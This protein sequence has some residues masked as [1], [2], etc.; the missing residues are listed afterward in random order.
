MSIL[1]KII[2]AG[3]I[4]AG[5][6]AISTA[7]LAHDA[8]VTPNGLGDTTSASPDKAHSCFYLSQWQNWHAPNPDVIYLRVRV[9]DIYRLDLSHPEPMLQDAFAH[10]ISREHG[11]DSVCGP[12]DLD[13]SVSDGEGF[14]APIFAKSITRL[15]PQQIALIPRKDLP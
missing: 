8:T 4:A 9:N 3:S 12:I 1:R 2:A 5:A 10:L 11:D 7:G 14:R 6:L 13:L 15:T